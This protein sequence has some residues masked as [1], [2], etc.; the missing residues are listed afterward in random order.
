[1]TAEAVA[2]TWVVLG[3]SSAIARAFAREAAGRGAAIILAGRDMDDMRRSAADIT[4]TTGREAAVLA[5]DALAFGSH[6]AFAAGLDAVAGVLNVAVLFGVMPEQQAMDADPALARFCIDSGF[7]GAVSILQHI[8]PLLE[9]RRA[10]CVIGVGSVAGDRGRLKNYVYGSAKAGLH[11]YLAGL[12][13]RLGRSGVHVLTVK[14]G[15]VD[16]A[17]T[18]GLPGL[19]LVA[20][21]EA[22][23]RRCLDAV[24]KRRDIIYAPW[25]WFVIMTI[26]RAV[27]E[28]VFKRLSV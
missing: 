21:P 2:E 14:P 4:A 7:T 16:T 28:R 11:T 25:F 22:I 23:A 17:M 3:A 1:V 19:F 5:F 24:A 15:F 26:I 6:A 10:G 27:P 12:R 8:A 13:N 18:F 9:R 20:Q